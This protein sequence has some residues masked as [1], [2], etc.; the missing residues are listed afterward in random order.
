MLLFGVDVAVPVAVTFGVDGVAVVA[1]DVVVDVVAV[2]TGAVVVRSSS[3]QNRASPATNDTTFYNSV[4]G[5]KDGETNIETG[6]EILCLKFIY[7]VG[8]NESQS[9]GK[10][11]P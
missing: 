2:D 6:C 11:G 10:N 8:G 5:Q 3:K 7:G 1:V 4:N 9:R